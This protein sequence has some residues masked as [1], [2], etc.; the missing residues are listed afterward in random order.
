MSDVHLSNPYSV[1]GVN[2]TDSLQTIEIAY[3]KLVKQTH[4]DTKGGS[5]DKFVE[6]NDAYTSIKKLMARSTHDSFQTREV[7]ADYVQNSRGENIA[8]GKVRTKHS[9]V[10]DYSSTIDISLREAVRGASLFVSIPITTMCEHCGGTGDVLGKSTL[11]YG[12]QGAG[13]VPKTSSSGS[14]YQ[15]C[16]ICQGTK[17]LVSNPCTW[18]KGSGDVAYARDINISI[19]AGSTTG[20]RICFPGAGIESKLGNG[21]LYI[22]INVLPDTAITRKGLDLHTDIELPFTKMTLGGNAEVN[23]WDDK[24]V[25][26]IEPGTP[27]N[28]VIRVRKKGSISTTGQVGDLVVH[29]R[30]QMPELPLTYKQR[31]AV[32]LLGSM[33]YK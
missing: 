21:D 30:L 4:P 24:V 26:P 15:V 23:M 6:V 27:P 33:L 12:C 18:C 8:D 13:E 16:N 28:K 5:Y 20:T 17:K 7:E 3:R 11:C 9:G 14:Y 32:K 10:Q 2:P 25:V 22:S 19:P 29:V 1:L 31:Q